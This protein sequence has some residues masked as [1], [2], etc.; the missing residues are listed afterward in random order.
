MT[1]LK[2]KRAYEEASP[3]D[4]FRVYVDRLWPQ[5]LSHQ[6]FHYN[7]W[8]KDVAP[9]TALRQWFHADPAGRWDEFKE[10]YDAELLSNTAFTALAD[11]LSPHPVAT[12]LFSSR[13]VTHDNARVLAQALIDTFPGKFRFS[14][15]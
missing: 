14:P 6:S 12:L 2:I 10:R 9:S 15:D 4:G 1:V 11:T 13:D 5:G 3:E 7:L 8:A